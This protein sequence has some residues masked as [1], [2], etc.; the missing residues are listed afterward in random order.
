MFNKLV[1]VA[2]LVVVTFVLSSCAPT[3]SGLQ[4][5]EAT[6][7]RPTNL[8]QPDAVEQSDSSMRFIA[9]QTE[10]GL[11]DAR[12]GYLDS[13][14]YQPW[15]TYVIR[16]VSRGTRV[17]VELSG[18]SNADFDLYVWSD[19]AWV[20]GCSTS[21]GC[22]YSSNERVE[23]TTSSSTDVWI[24]PYAYSGSGQYSLIIGNR[25]RYNSYSC[26]GLPATIWGTEGADDLRGTSQSD[27]IVGLGGND[28]I[29]GEGGNDIICGGDGNDNISGGSGNDELFGGDG[30]DRITGGP[31][32]DVIKGGYG[33]DRLWGNG[34]SGWDR[35]YSDTLE[36]EEGDDFLVGY[37]YDD[38]LRGGPGND[39]LSGL[40]GDDYL[41][42]GQGWDLLKG[43]RDRDICINGED[44]KECP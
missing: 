25:D 2:L 35:P 32:S 24:F 20:A 13:S 36:G 22:T 7:A 38:I 21:V 15:D 10:I 18:P 6:K 11:N 40:E 42:G 27:V 16:N 8:P 30:Q 17:I 43:G 41:D 12:S 9:L 19:G 44:I 14:D 3:L 29:Y 33:N 1:S 39:E 26:K 5:T 34:E 23:F 31:G 37:M 28:T 4:D